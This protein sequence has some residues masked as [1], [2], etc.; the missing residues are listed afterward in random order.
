MY[1]NEKRFYNNESIHC[2]YGGLTKHNV[3]GLNFY[4]NIKENNLKDHAV[5]RGEDVLFES[6]KTILIKQQ[7]SPNAMRFI[8]VQRIRY[9][10]LK[11][12][13]FVRIHENTQKKKE[14]KWVNV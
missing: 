10:T 4:I 14:K 3:S 7:S 5:A 8:I 2:S 1:N 6:T 9:I 12:L 11:T 13:K